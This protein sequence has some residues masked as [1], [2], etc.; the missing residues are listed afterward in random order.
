[1]AGPSSPIREWRE[2]SE[3]NHVGY[4]ARQ[5]HVAASGI[6]LVFVTRRGQSEKIEAR[7]RNGGWVG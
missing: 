2:V 4:F 1:M 5:K 3:Q 7:W 6:S